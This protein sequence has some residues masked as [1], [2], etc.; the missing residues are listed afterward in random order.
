MIVF[1]F[2]CI[3]FHLLKA[4]GWKVVNESQLPIVCFTHPDIE[5]NRALTQKL[6]D[7]MN[8]SKTTWMSSYPINGNL[9]LRVQIPNFD[10][11]EEDLEQFVNLLDEYKKRQCEK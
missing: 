3:H 10:T 5:K 7:E 9:T 1:C 2:K 4:K 8:L 11:Q 6:V